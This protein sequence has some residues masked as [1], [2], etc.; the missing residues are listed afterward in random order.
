M[1]HVY[2]LIFNHNLG[3]MQVASELSCAAGCG[4]RTRWCAARAMSARL[5]G[6]ALCMA[7]MVPAAQAADHNW[8]GSGM[9]DWNDAASWDTG[10]VPVAADVVQL[11][12]SGTLTLGDGDVGAV[13]R[14]RMHDGILQIHGKLWSG[15]AEF[16]IH[17]GSTAAVVVSG[18][19]AVWDGMSQLI[20]GLSGAGTLRVGGGGSG[21]SH[22]LFIGGY[23]GS[24]G[25]MTVTGAGSR[26][27]NSDQL[28]VGVTAAGSL[29]VEQGGQLLSTGRSMLG[30]N[31]TGAG[32]VVVSGSGSRWQNANVLWIGM[33]GSGTL[34]IDKAGTVTSITTTLADGPSGTGTLNLLGNSIG[35]R[36][37][38][39]TGQLIDGLGD[40]TLNLNGG[41]L[42]ATH[43][44][45]NYLSGFSTLA[46]GGEGAWFDTA[47]FNIEVGTAFS[48]P[49]GGG[50]N[51][52]GAGTLTLS[53]DSSA[54]SGR[55]TINAGTL[56]VNNALGGDVQVNSGGTLGGN[57]RI[58]G[59]VQV[60][61]GAT[62]AAGNS[63]GTLTIDGDLTLQHGAT[64][65]FELNQPGVV[66]GANND[67][68]DV[69]GNLALDGN[70]QASVSSAGWYR[71]FNHGGALS[72]GFDSVTATVA[73]S[74]GARALIDTATAHQVNLSVLAS[75]HTMQF[76]NGSASGAGVVGGS[77]SWSSSGNNWTDASGTTADSWN[78]SVAVFMGTAG[79]VDVLGMQSF[80]TLQ[81]KTD[82]YRLN[83]GTGGQLALS[84]A[85]GSAATINIDG[86][87]HAELDVA[88]VDGSGNALRKVGA[89]TLTLRAA[90]SYSGGTEVSEGSLVVAGNNV[91]GSGVVRVDNSPG[92]DA[93]LQV[94]AGNLL[95]NALILDNGGTLDNAGGVDAGVTP[96]RGGV[97]GAVIRNQGVIVGGT[98]AVDLLGGGDV[99]NAAGA[100]IGAEVAL[101]SGGAVMLDN[102]GVLDGDVQLAENAQHQVTLHAYS[103]VSGDL[104]IGSNAAS[105]L[106]LDVDDGLAYL[107]SHAVVGDTRFSGQLDKRGAGAW[108]IDRDLN[109]ASTTLS[110]GILQL[111]TSAAGSTRGSLGDGAIINLGLLVIARD[112]DF[113]MRN[114]ISG[115]GGF[116]KESSNTLTLTGNNHSTGDFDIQ[117]GTLV[118]SGAGSV[119]SG[120]LFFGNAGA[121]LD[122]SAADG[123][124]RIAALSGVEGSSIVLGANDLILGDATNRSFDGVLSGS[125]GIVKQGSGTQTLA[126]ANTYSGGTA[127][128]GGT[129]AIA[130]TG[131]LD[132]RGDVALTASG[133]VFD[134]S[135]ANKVQS[136]GSLTGVSGS[137]VSVGSNALRFSHTDAAVFSGSFIG[138]GAL[139]KQ[140]S[141][142]LLFDGDNRAFVG[143]MTVDAGTLRLNGQLGGDMQVNAAAALVGNGHIGGN[144]ELAGTLA[145]GN[146]IGALEIGG[147]LLLAAGSTYAAEIDAS[148]GDAVHAGGVATLQGGTLQVIALDEKTS[149][150]DGYRYTLLSA[151]GGITGSFGQLVTPS[152]FLPLALDYSGNA[153]VLRIDQPRDFR[154]AAETRNQRNTADALNTLPQAGEA[155]ALY[156][157]LLMYDAATARAAFDALSGEIHA[158]ARALLLDDRFV[159]DAV[160]RRL[161]G[162]VTQTQGQGGTLWLGGSGGSARQ[163]GDGNGAQSHD[164]RD[165]ML[166][167]AD[168][169]LGEQ[170]VLGAVIG[171]QRLRQ[172][173]SAHDSLAKA[174]DTVVG[175]YAQGR[176]GGLSVAGNVSYSRYRIDSERTLQLDGL[177][178]QTLRAN[179]DA[180]ATTAQLEMAWTQA[181]GT[182]QMQP[183]LQLT[184]QWLGNDAAQEWGGPAALVV[185]GDDAQRL[186]SRVGV[187]GIWDF[188]GGSAAS[189]AVL[190][191][192]LGWEHAGG[193][194]SASS[195]QCFAAGGEAFEVLSTARARNAVVG[196][197][198]V[199]VATG[200]RSQLS[201]AAQAR[202]GDGVRELGAQL[203][204][205]L[206]F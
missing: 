187:R 64:T 57:G 194:L 106:T 155:L 135:H 6:A 172:R 182:M 130:G 63:P 202:S 73:S 127:I 74:P 9:A 178:A 149:Y 39:I 111:G 190:R 133:A 91:L 112:D 59:D 53:G 116:V 164:Y 179:H 181:L 27:S 50:L 125:G 163:D 167:G 95:S 49:T 41:I 22:Q 188:S 158:G 183:Y 10:R 94:T 84:P 12:G 199:D 191:V 126:G 103:T 25:S 2:R 109:A 97:G 58:A 86:G 92:R 128:Q 100:V 20:V 35:G 151:D 23:A 26:W 31:Q 85:S 96:V 51:K 184:S 5:L 192:G 68:I 56:A 104:D 16:G 33:N 13:N 169:Q 193:D 122:M 38:L 154:T 62:L 28:Q 19:D 203:N 174:Q 113:T 201:L 176:W 177:G 148:H 67:L 79:V 11:Y 34:D 134:I 17:S 139:T 198:A 71:L 157:T 162:D 66:G 36:G 1:N 80:D 29:L 75:G 143:R 107:H 44:Q 65:V 89:G 47:G 120:A 88:L 99:H 170:G 123:H 24:G 45:L 150:R 52:Q 43:S 42:Q 138:D 102:A 152:A 93:T 124:R 114:A 196:E 121:T 110:E 145:P 165:G 147:D 173:L 54:F 81:F 87:V 159:V 72:G 131:S 140:G 186:V 18:T 175:L 83:A 82:G 119:G 200:G 3:L 60:V 90:S 108:I 78:N 61:D 160:N 204:W 136:I 205:R 32:S 105:T 180:Q 168:L 141:G 21:G 197:A 189:S 8:F 101:R 76:W 37:V 70:L 206:G 117:R 146:S 132:E 4:G 46:V 156:N 77:G 129:L 98:L 15:L 30:V 161:H 144:L 185:Q 55:T 153:L 137:I 166:L 171:T 7:L 40:A 48:S 118:L 115:S 142:S 195:R 69:G 14:I